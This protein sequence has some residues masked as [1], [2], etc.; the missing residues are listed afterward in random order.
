MRAAW[1]LSKN[2]L[3]G[4]PARTLLLVAAV[5]LSTAL[6]ATVACALSSLN[7]GMSYRIASTIGSS[8]LQVRH[9]TGEKLRGTLAE[10]IRMQPGV[11]AAAGRAGAP[12][13]VRTSPDGPGE[14]LSVRARDPVHEPRITAFEVDEGRPPRAPGE[15]VL[16]A[17]AFEDD[18]PALGDILYAGDAPP[19]EEWRVVGVVKPRTIELVNQSGAHVTLQTL[20]R[21]T[22]GSA[23]R[24]DD[25]AVV[26][27]QGAD[28]GA[29]RENLLRLVPEQVMVRES[30][31]LAS[32]IGDKMQANE[33]IFVLALVLTYIASGF[34]VLTGLTTGVLERQRELAI[35][36][37]IGSP[38]WPLA[39]VQLV[40]GGTIGAAGALVGIPAGIALAW[41]ATVVFPERLPAGLHVSAIGLTAAGA[42][43]VVSGLIGSAWSAISAA[44]AEPLVAMRSR[45]E[46]PSR[47]GLVLVAA[48]GAALVAVQATIVLAIADPDLFFAVYAAVG[49]PAMFIGY[50]LLGVPLVLGLSTTLARPLG[51]ALGLPA[52]MLG[53][54]VRQTPY[55]NGFTAGAL[56]IGVAMMTSVYTN[57]NAFLR[58]WFD[59]I[60][61]P[62]AFA[63]GLLVG[64]DEDTERRIA[65]LGI[66]ENT[67]AITL[68]RVPTD[69][70]GLAR[71]TEPTTNFIGFEVDP[72]FEMTRLTWAAGD[73]EYAK[74]RLREGGAVLVAEEFLVAREGFGVGETF[75]IRYRGREIPFEIVGAVSSPGLD[76][77]KRYFDFEEEYA[78]NS[79]HAVFGSRED[80][81]K[82]FGIETVHLIQID[83][84]DEVGDEAA[85]EAIEAAVDRDGVVVGS[86][87]AIKAEIEEVGRGSMRVAGLIAVATMLIGCV[88]V[89]N[90]V[91][92]GI[93]A[94]RY[95][96]GVLRSVGA[97]RWLVAR[98]LVGEV[99][100]VALAA[101]LLGAAMG[102]QGS[103]AGLH[104]FRLVAGL[105]LRLVP[106]WGP[107]LFASVV[108]VLLT[109][110]ATWPIVYRLTRRTPRELLASR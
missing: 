110:T 66:V 6:V 100:V 93:D 10:T 4:R 22:P 52:N 62:D 27:E 15:V 42:G 31:R 69:A 73:P 49:V 79:I 72:F 28:V 3:A 70:F 7:A 68:F 2:A 41:L 30:T 9:V 40:A 60:R 75:P 47:R 97:G 19:F 11:A 36:R 99:L 95:E 67:S 24:L 32:G 90:I 89:A 5:A 58:D 44:R 74:R 23:L 78:E 98:L 37:C 65:R 25:V 104:V 61:F 57:G 80:L 54:S 43:A 21:A 26:V 35:L 55:R 92:A 20:R 8:D 81:K 103:W 12:V 88:G 96:F 34:I 82:H 63:N 46:P 16:E 59:A 86:G 38:R 84:T 109:A 18:P 85:V 106:A 1:R 50:F 108:L 76:I 33:F 83:L 77:V 45:A 91:V 13:R 17:T 56:M 101:C 48:G 39:A 102:L 29:V 64:L 51:A 71:L 94:R 105:E 14:V 53:R 87:K 107:M